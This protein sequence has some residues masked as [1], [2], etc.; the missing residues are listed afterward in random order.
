[1]LNDIHY[2]INNIETYGIILDVSVVLIVHEDQHLFF[3]FSDDEE[4]VYF[5]VD[6]SPN[7]EAEIDDKLVKNTREDS[8][9][10]FP[11]FLELKADLF[12]CSYEEN[13]DDIYVLETNCFGS[14]NYD[15][16]VVSNT[17]QKQPI[18]DEYLSEEDKEQSLFMVSLE[19]HRIVP[20]YDD[21]ESDPW[22]GHAGE[23]EE[24]NVHLI[25]CPTLVNEKISPGIIQP[26]LILYPPIHSENTKKQVRNSEVKEV[27]SYQVSVP[28]YKF[29]DLVGLYMELSFPKDLEPAKLFILSSFGGI[30]SVPKH[31]FILLSYFPY[32]LW[33][34]CSEK[35][36]YVTK[37]F[38]WL[39][40][41]FFFTS[42]IVKID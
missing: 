11:R 9:L 16:E 5:A 13:V 26:A 17:D 29:Y 3:E 25:S 35:K 10:V 34:I 2:D 14:P 6:I 18:F 37:Q 42:H 20:V 36:N 39:W 27:I 38:R 12:C 41:K 1:V 40:W 22:E 8:S 21:Y 7:Y 15:E 19:P 24:L 23:K 31:V 33:I 28:Y 4:K 30:V 32:F